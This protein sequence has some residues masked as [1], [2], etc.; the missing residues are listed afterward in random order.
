[1][2][3]RVP[4]RF[5]NE[6]ISPACNGDKAVIAAFEAVPRKLFVEAA[7]QAHAYDDIALPIGMG[8]TIS[9]PSTVA[10]MLSQL[11]LS[12][13]DTVLE[14]GAGSG[15]VTALLS[16]MVR[17]VYA[18]ERIPQLFEKARNAIRAMGIRNALFRSGDGGAG[19][20]EFAPFDKIIASAGAS[21]LP[22]ALPNQLKEG[23]IILIPVKGHLMRYRKKSGELM[24]EKGVQVSFVEFV[25]S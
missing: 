23:G 2:A 16:L 21:A 20:D 9:Q 19:W 6:I 7:M 10:H 14:I 25:G 24:E 11:E 18:V 15:F 3:E 4:Q 5:I 22:K 13:S 8:Q 1:M 12:K 17:Q